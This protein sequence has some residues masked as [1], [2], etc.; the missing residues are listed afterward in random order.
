MNLNKLDLKRNL[1]EIQKHLEKQEEPWKNSCV[2]IT[3][4]VKQEPSKK[5]KEKW[6]W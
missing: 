6:I 3:F 1:L 4:E 5:T 2:S